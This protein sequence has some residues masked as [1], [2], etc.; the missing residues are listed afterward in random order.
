ARRERGAGDVPVGGVREP[1]VAAFLQTTRL[2]LREFTE[3]DAEALR[4]L[5][6]D[7]EVRRYVGGEVPDVEAYRRMITQ[8]FAAG[9]AEG[10]GFWAAQE[11][12]SGEFLGWFHLRPA[13]E[14]RYAN[15]AGYRPGDIDLGYRLRRAAWGRGYA[16]EGAL[17]LVAYAFT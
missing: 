15:E 6:G 17:A 5:D 8:R 2:V 1:P 12:A 13:R 3:A 11:K 16:T 4:E 7:P 10:W 14:Y 9:Y